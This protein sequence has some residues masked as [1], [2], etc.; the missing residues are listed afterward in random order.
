MITE[1]QT[2]NEQVDRWV[3][4][5]V[6][7]GVTT[8][9][10]LLASL[11]GVYPSVV[12]DS[13]KRLSAAGKFNAQGFV[14]T[15]EAPEPN[16]AGREQ[17]STRRR[18]ITLPVPHPL[19][20]DWRFGE[21][22]VSYLL[23]TC[24]D[25]TRPD[26]TIALLG[27]PS[28]LRTAIESSYPRAT[29]LLDANA[30]VVNCLSQAAPDAEV[31]LCDVVRDPLPLIEASAVIVD[32]P[33]Y[34]EHLAGFLWAASSLCR[35]GGHVLVSTP[36]VGTRPGIDRDRKSLL[37]WARELGLTLLRTEAAVLP[38]CSPPF[39]INA[40]KA[41][42]LCG[43]LED[44]RRGDLSIFVKEAQVTLPRPVIPAASEEKWVE[45]S[46]HGVRVRVRPSESSDFNDPKLLTIVGGDILPSASRRDY[47]R[48][49]VDVWTSGNRVFASQGR[50]VLIHIL[51]ALATENSPVEAVARHLGRG[52]SVGEQTLVGNAIIRM[53]EIINTERRE[54]SLIGESCIDA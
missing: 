40:L 3:Y 38:Y 21:S 18:R 14:I 20:Y 1:E 50:N 28:V 9:N 35:A 4:G 30:S 39:E 29:A 10:S 42:G 51:R 6:T 34:E 47:R 7:H 5:A 52:L 22:A 23:D 54:N 44:W 19:D 8:F 49:L 53:T 45:E 33:W 31:L 2:F 48:A 15:P 24:L 43:I 11:P 32:P 13:L 46:L 41:E 25:L 17:S 37:D 12:L 26:E 27:T 16:G 36:P